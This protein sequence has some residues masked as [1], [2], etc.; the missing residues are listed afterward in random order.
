MPKGGD[1][2]ARIDPNVRETPLSRED[3]RPRHDAVDRGGTD[4]LIRR[5]VATDYFMCE[6]GRAV[7]S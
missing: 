6:D 2:T 7:S 4:F 1:R 3:G 5:S